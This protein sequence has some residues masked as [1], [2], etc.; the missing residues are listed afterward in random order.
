MQITPEG[1]NYPQLFVALD[2]AIEGLLSGRGREGLLQGSFSCV[3]EGFGAEKALILLVMP[4]GG[5]HS[6]A[7]RG[8]SDEEVAACEAG[9]SVPGISS[10]KIRETLERRSPLLVQDPR[11]LLGSQT[12]R[13]LEGKPFS[14]LC[15]PISDPG[16]SRSLAVFYAQNSGFENGFTEIDFS[17]IEVWSNVMGR[18][19]SAGPQGPLTGPWGQS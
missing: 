1:R 6:L 3:V 14:V 9:R 7:S 8:L 16:R 13:A 17:F 2:E 12:T 5:L 18:L 4:D 19:L 10:S 15:A 11:H